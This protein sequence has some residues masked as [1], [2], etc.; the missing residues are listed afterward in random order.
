MKT[1]NLVTLRSMSFDD[2]NI[3]IVREPSIDFKIIIPRQKIAGIDD[4]SLN[5]SLEFGWAAYAAQQLHN[6]CTDLCYSVPSPASLK[7]FEFTIETV[8]PAKFAG[9]LYRLAQDYNS[10]DPEIILSSFQYMISTFYIQRGEQKKDAVFTAWGLL[11]VSN[12]QFDLP[13]GTLKARKIRLHK[14]SKSMKDNK[15]YTGK[16]DRVRVDAKDASEVEYLHSKYPALTHRMIR[17]AI[18]IA[19]PLRKNITK[20]LNRKKLKIK[21]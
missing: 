19:G 18:T 11:Y 17:N 16:K 14:K 7:P 10:R 21:N 13:P 8:E 20:Y 12:E 4:I 2:L 3:S 9:V 15:K 6:V 1:I 5:N